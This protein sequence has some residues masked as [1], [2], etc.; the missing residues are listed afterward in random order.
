MRAKIPK[1]EI[2]IGR[3]VSDPELWSFNACMHVQPWTEIRKSNI[4]K[5]KKLNSSKNYSKKGNHRLETAFRKHSFDQELR[6]TICK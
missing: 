6:S 1:L 5:Y 2:D 4:I 3:N